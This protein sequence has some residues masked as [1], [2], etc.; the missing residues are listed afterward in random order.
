MPRF[1]AVFFDSGGTLWIPPAQGLP[2]GHSLPELWQRRAARVAACLAGLGR[3][4][5]ESRIAALLPDL[6][7][8]SPGRF[9][10]SY[11]YI[12]LMQ[13]L[14]EA[15]GETW[16]VEDHLLLA[17]AYVGPRYRSWLGAG[18]EQTLAALADA[19]VYVGLISNTYIPGQSV[20]RLFR[21]VGLL[22]YLR[23]RIY[24]GDEGISKPEAG[25]F[26]LA[27]R[28]A[29]L[30]G[31]RLLYVGDDLENDVRAS[32][33]AGW[34]AVLIRSARADSGGLADF[35]ITRL[36]ELLDFVL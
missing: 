26:E 24:S 9:G 12:D 17:D 3:A 33:R 34:S 18:T 35:E 25:I 2:P 1:D 4:A 14:A 21:G 22:K 20:D 30:E 31:R 23:T 8:A 29:G 10:P 28:R 7:A 27:V 32:R 36:P 13:A 19:G 16:C 6:E 5:S 15:L 11:T